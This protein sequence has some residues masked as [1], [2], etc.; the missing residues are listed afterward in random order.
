MKLRYSNDVLVS[1]HH[2]WP[3]EASYRK[4]HRD[5]SCQRRELPFHRTGDCLRTGHTPSDMELHP[6][7]IPSTC[8]SLQIGQIVNIIHEST[9]VFYQKNVQRMLL[10]HRKSELWSHHL[11]DKHQSVSKPTKLIKLSETFYFPQLTGCD[12]GRVFKYL[13]GSM[14]TVWICVKWST[15]LWKPLI[16]W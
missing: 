12:E 10:T 4:V 15:I 2:I 13:Y 9:L 7:G 11:W 6:P 1:Y 5:G 14:Y 16:L 8:Y 3:T